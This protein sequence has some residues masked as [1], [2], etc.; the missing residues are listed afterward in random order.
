MR[1]KNLNWGEKRFYSSLYDDSFMHTVVLREKKI[2]AG[3]HYLSYNPLRWLIQN[4]FAYLIAYPIIWL[5][6][7]FKYGVRVK[8]KK[9]IRKVKGGA[10]LI[11]N[12]SNAMDG[13]FSSVHVAY[14]RRN[15]IITNKD[16]VQVPVGKWFTKA[17]G[18]LPLPDEPKGLSNLAN[19]VD[20]LVHHGCYVT[21]FP[22]ACIW[23]YHTKLRPLNPA[24]FHYAVKSD[25]P[26][27]PFCVT[28]RYAKGRNYLKKKPKVNITI[29]EPIYPDNSLS[30]SECKIKLAKETENRMREVIESRDNVMLYNYVEVSKPLLEEQ[31]NIS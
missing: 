5:I 28:Y 19:T 8:G 12:H 10:I 29:L 6:D 11:G 17:L 21:I 26:V 24:A 14:P 31:K 18:A 25:V 3:Y 30:K 23:P 1:K 16:A 15:Y 27:V 22:E 9:N 7:K 4:I 13:C 2:K 20:K